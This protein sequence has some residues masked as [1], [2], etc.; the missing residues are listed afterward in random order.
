MMG[1]TLAVL[2][3]L[4]LASPVVDTR[5]MC[6]IIAKD[7]PGFCH[8]TDLSTG[9]KTDCQLDL[10]GSDTIVSELDFEPCADVA[11]LELSL[12]EAL[13]NIKKTLTISAGD[14]YTFTVPGPH[15]NVPGINDASLTVSALMSGN[16]DRL[17]AQVSLDICG[18]LADHPV[19]GSDTFK[20]LPITVL[21]GSWTFSDVCTGSVAV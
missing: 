21:N 14:Q 10:L 9:S 3:I 15:I 13:H 4:A 20:Q 19:C 18:T 2:P 7:L 17:V 11:H 8:C 5:S 1:A 16:A 12:T 6:S